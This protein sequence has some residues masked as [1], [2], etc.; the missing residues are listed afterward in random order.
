MGDCVPVEMIKAAMV[1]RS[2]PRG[3]DLICKPNWRESSEHWTIELWIL[4]LFTNPKI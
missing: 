2:Y 1:T 3:L 4:R